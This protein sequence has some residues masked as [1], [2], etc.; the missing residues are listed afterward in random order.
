MRRAKR[1]GVVCVAGYF[2]LTA[3]GCNPDKADGSLFRDLSPER[4][5]ITFRNDIVESEQMNILDYLY[6]YNGGGVAIGDLNND[7]LADVYFTS[8]QGPNQLYINKGGL[9]FEDVTANA[10]VAGGSSD[11]DWTTGTTLVD[12]NNDGWLDIYVCQVH[13]FGNLQGHNKLFVNNRD[14]TFTERAA[15]YGL[16]TASYAQQATFFDYDK[17]GD[18]D[19]YLLNFAVH[20]PNSYKRA[21]QRAGRDSLAGDRLYRNVDGYYE[22]VS[23]EAGIYGGSMGY[24][25]AVA[26]SDLNN[27][28]W[29]DIYVSNDFHEN[30]YLYYNQGDGTFRE[31]I[32]NSMGHT[33]TFSMGSDIADVNND[34]WQDVI[35][36][37]MKPADEKLLKTLV[38]EDDFNIYALKLSYGYHYQ[39]PRNMLQI[40]KG[41]LKEN[42]VAFSEVGEMTG[43]S[44]TDWSWSPLFAD[45]DGDGY[46]DLFIT[47]GIPRRP[48]NLDFIKYTSNNQ[49]RADSLDFSELIAAI[50]EGKAANVAYRNT[51]YGFENV[52]RKW[53]LA[54]EGYSNGAAVA[55]LDN[56]GDPDLVVNNLNGPASVYENTSAGEKGPQYLKIALH[57]SKGNT[58]GIGALVSVTTDTGTQTREFFPGKGWLS[59]MNTPMAFGLGTSSSVEEVS[60]RWPDGSVQTLRNPKAE[61]MLTLSH[62]DAVN[63][64]S[65][66]SEQPEKPIF[67]PVVPGNGIAFM[68]EE[69]NFIDFE[70][71][72]LIPRMLSREGPK[73]AVADLNKDGLDDF[74]IGGAKDQAGAIYLQQRDTTAPFKRVSNDDF[75]VDRASEDVG[76]VF[77]DV[78]ND[79][80]PDLYVVSGGGEP[81]Q[82]FT[83]M[84]R[85]YINEGQGKFR[86]SLSHPQL[87]FNGSCVVPADF[88]ED[89]ITDLFVGARSIPG[90]YGK[91]HRS[92]ILIGNAQGALFDITERIFG[93][94]VN[95]GMV[96]D[97]AWLPESRELVVVGEWMDVTVLDFKYLPLAEKKIPNTSGW[98]NTIHAADMDQDGDLDLIAGNLGTN[99]NLKA[100]KQ[101]PVNLYIHDLDENQSP[102]A[103][104]SHYRDGVEYPYYGLELLS[105]QLVA[106]KKKYPDYESFANSSFSEVFPAAQ[107][108]GAGRA[109]AVT[110]ESAYYENQG[111]GNFQSRSL[112]DAAQLAPIYGFATDDFDGDGSMDLLAV[113]NNSG[114][115]V[116]I[117][118]L[119]ASYGTF[120]SMDKD[121]QE[122][123]NTEART[124]GLAVMGDSRDIRILQGPG[125]IKWV[126]V[127]RNNGPVSLF[128]YRGRNNEAM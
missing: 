30:D 59:A 40:N 52:S 18:L 83:K 39:Y 125:T 80:L 111:G 51:G 14:G 58:S 86:K 79:Q 4:T 124:S 53:G 32:R 123:K 57:G 29:P 61:K 106:L 16:N 99:T 60:V 47:N 96:T 74:Y 9:Q 66:K 65:S 36:L 43:V 101:E 56:D 109:Q 55:D 63:P 35:T 64:S 12:I 112:P 105:K 17:D 22:D 67:S 122:W 95:L 102:E 92:R 84:D 37:D 98:W 78:N 21:T 108:E 85:L 3:I 20:T 115:Q 97:A 126:L 48:N 49:M 69:N 90:A 113:G 5:G 62:A 46:Q 72:K 116:K 38:G 91:F 127:A 10:G 75:F 11:A 94:R 41:E 8:N 1:L 121:N 15:E 89:G 26:L 93:D 100:S 110:F 23:E 118:N 44:A 88:N 2:L 81:F 13:G 28:G 42:I 71:E 6:M 34:G 82:D 50:P 25:L 19:M 117:G 103:I 104:L 33:S 107:M 70:F 31:D 77:L 68:H 24:G 73:I 128:R 119:D 76:A 45:F 54:L 27:D 7:G 114:N 87:A 120:I